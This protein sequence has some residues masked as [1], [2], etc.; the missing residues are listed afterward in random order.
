MTAHHRDRLAAAPDLDLSVAV[1][2]YNGQQLLARTL[3]SPVAQR[4]DACRYEAMVVDNNSDDGT[5]QVVEAR[6]AKWP[7]VR[8]LHEPRPNIDCVGRR[9]EA[10]WAAPSPAWLTAPEGA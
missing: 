8:Y 10:R 9:I 5:R 1:P 7:Y 6:V 4:A 3:E 2:T